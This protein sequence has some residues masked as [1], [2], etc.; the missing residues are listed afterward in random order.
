[1]EPSRP[2]P[3][4]P[5]ELGFETI[6]YEKAPPRATIR[7]NRPDV[8]NAFDFRMLREIARACEDASWDDDV[9][10]VVV[11]GTGRAFCSGADLASWDADYLGRPQEYWKWFGAFKDMHDRLRDLGK[12]TIAR[13]NGI[14]VGGGNELQLACD[15]AVIVDDAYIRHVGLEHGSV[16][17]GGAT[18]WLS[19]LVGDRRAREIILLCDEISPAQA[20]D[21][22]L[23][24]RAVSP[25][26]L[27]AVVDA[28][29]ESLARKLPNATRYAKHQLNVWRDLAWHQTVGHARDWLAL[30]M[31]SGETQ[32]AVK[33][34]LDSRGAPRE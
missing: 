29:V 21:W 34:F 25:A 2:L 22:G 4:S 5:E 19:L 13:I 31:L 28:W 3:S 12:P 15:L 18:Q 26:E 7:L 10:A 1:M 23:V 33:A 20:E 32:D 8:L 6:V 16:P 17:A 9:R 24:N 14:V 11:T 30:S 27:D